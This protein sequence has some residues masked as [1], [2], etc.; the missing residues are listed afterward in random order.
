MHNVCIDKEIILIMRNAFAQRNVRVNRG[1]L[2]VD[3]IQKAILG[4]RFLNWNVML[5][6]DRYSLYV[7][8]IIKSNNNFSIKGDSAGLVAMHMLTVVAR[9]DTNN[10]R[11]TQHDEAEL[12]SQNYTH[13]TYM[14]V[15]QLNDVSLRH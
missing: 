12:S 15:T 1:D 5:E 9:Y 7:L 10:N 2:P 13:H 6:D 14:I 4:S 3:K 8:N 11:G